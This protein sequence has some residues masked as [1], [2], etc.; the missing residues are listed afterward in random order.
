MKQVAVLGFV[1]Q[2]RCSP[3][4][5]LSQW[6]CSMTTLLNFVIFLS[7]GVLARRAAAAI[8]CARYPH[9]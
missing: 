7:K 2:S 9:C 4:W 6:F 8:P 3:E 1:G 5:L